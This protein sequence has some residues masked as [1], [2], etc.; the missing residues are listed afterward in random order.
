MLVALLASCIA[1]FTT[2]CG[3]SFDDGPTGQSNGNNPGGLTGEV[4]T[5]NFG[6]ATPLPR[7]EVL[8]QEVQITSIPNGTSS[9][10]VESVDSAGNVVRLAGAIAE[11]IDTVTG[12]RSGI[13]SF[14]PG[15]SVN[16]VL[17]QS[18]DLGATIKVETQS[19]HS[20][21]VITFKRENNI[22]TGVVGIKD[23]SGVINNPSGFL[24]HPDDQ[25]ADG[26]FPVFG[27]FG[28]RTLLGVGAMEQ[29]RVFYGDS[30]NPDPEELTSAC[31]FS[32][33]DPSIVTVDANGKLTAVAPGTAEV[34]Y[35]L[36]SSI[37][38]ST[39]VNVEAISISPTNQEVPI[40]GNQTFTINGTFSSRGTWS[41]EGNTGIGSIDPNTGVFTASN[42]LAGT[43]TIRFTTDQ[44]AS[45]TA[46]VT[47]VPNVA[48][49]FTGLTIGSADPQRLDFTNPGSTAQI[50][51]V[52]DFEGILLPFPIA[53]YAA[54]ATFTNGSTDV[55]LVDTSGLVTSLPQDGGTN[56]TVST[57]SLTIS[58]ELDGV[59]QQVTLEVRTSFVT[60]DSAIFF[61]SQGTTTVAPLVDFFDGS[62]T[63]TDVTGDPEVSFSITPTGQGVT[64]NPDGS[65]TT[66]AGATPGEYTFTLTYTLGGSVFTQ[67]TTVFVQI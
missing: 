55:F 22:I 53:D 33:E 58:Y 31:Y 6:T 16:I 28:N 41:L 45:V 17:P 10:C 47:V 44:G 67:D 43:G 29:F 42:V 32:S 38:G 20:G 39:T 13:R 50:E 66:T 14:G 54:N 5:V 62:L 52:G 60:I 57:N 4:V 12:Q 11:T 49:I 27:D 30:L 7:A 48:G 65:I 26:R 1:F 8:G 9:I 25:L 59:T 61:L 18:N 63:P 34:F 51:L 64:V 46:Q 15:L 36:G 40:G 23:A 35:A 56:P 19:P 24:I 2:G 37:K 21:L 3:S